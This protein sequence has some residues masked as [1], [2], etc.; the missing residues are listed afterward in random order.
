M[1][2]STWTLSQ[3][4]K[5]ALMAKLNTFLN[6][7]Q[8]L[9]QTLES[10][11]ITDS[12]ELLEK[13]RT[14]KDRIQLS[15]EGGVRF[16]VVE[17]LAHVVD[18]M[19]IEGIDPPLASLLEVSGIRSVTE[20]SSRNATNLGLWLRTVNRVKRLVPEVPSADDIEKWIQAARTLEG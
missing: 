11:G 1:A 8:D 13:T 12:D 7:D 18:L 5:T 17:H 2:N 4:E 9:L 3:P 16:E 20:L 10:L 19:R 15:T 6:I 14:L